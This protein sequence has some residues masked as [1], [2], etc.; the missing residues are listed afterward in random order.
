MIAANV[1]LGV[2]VEVLA[3][4]AMRGVGIYV[5]LNRRAFGLGIRLFGDTLG[6]GRLVVLVT[7][8]Y[9]MLAP[10]I[11]PHDL[12]RWSRCGSDS[13]TAGIKGHVRGEAGANVQ[14]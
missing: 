5:P 14:C 8:Q 10:D 3:V 4:P 11:G 1:G 13:K 6:G 9:K 12:K 7:H 2:A